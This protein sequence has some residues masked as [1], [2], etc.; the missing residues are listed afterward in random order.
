MPSRHRN[1]LLILILASAALPSRL[2][3][4]TM[5]EHQHT[6]AAPSTS[7]VLTIDGKATQLSV[8]D[9][10]SLPQKTITVLNEHTKAHETYTGVLLSDLLAKYGFAVGQPT[11][12]KMLH[13]YIK[14]EGTDKYWVLYSVTEVEGSE[15][16]ADVIVAT[17]LNGKPLGDDGQIK[18][19]ASAEKRPQRWVR[20]LSAITLVTVP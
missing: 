9:L 4:Q 19:V 20:N 17:A 16:L 8:S 14:A 3:G 6:Q 11:H 7:L 13:S 1:C 5:P 10:Q 15:H 18:L 2:H 12:Q